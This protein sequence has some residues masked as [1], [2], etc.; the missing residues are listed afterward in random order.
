MMPCIR[1]SHFTLIDGAFL[2]VPFTPRDTLLESDPARPP[3]AEEE[4]AQD[5]GACCGLGGR[6]THR[7]QRGL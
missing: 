1:I 3:R 4:A 7:G 6:V 2:K 5:D